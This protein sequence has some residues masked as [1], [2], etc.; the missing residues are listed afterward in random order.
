MINKLEHL[1]PPPLVALLI[2]V[3]IWYGTTAPSTPGPLRWSLIG[4][5]IA[6]GLALDFSA[7]ISFLKRHTT[8]NPLAP[9]HASQ[10]VTDGMYRFTR[11]PMYLGLALNLSAWGLYLGSWLLLPAL[12]VFVGYITRFQILPEERA[13]QLKFGT[14]FTSYCNT[15][16]R[17]L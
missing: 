17:W 4:L 7:I 9:D 12:L 13:L 15:V 11:N 3:A 1:I 10:L 5:L 14:D 6:C 16:R 2:A 8:V